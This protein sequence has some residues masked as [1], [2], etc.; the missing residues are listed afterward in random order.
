VCCAT[1]AQISSYFRPR[2]V[3]TRRD[4]V[5]ANIGGTGLRQALLQAI[6]TGRAK[7]A[8]FDHLGDLAQGA[9][10]LDAACT[11]AGSCSIVVLH[12]ARV[13]NSTVCSR[14]SHAAVALLHHDRKDKPSV[15]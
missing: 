1:Q 8:V 5:L 9:W 4:V 14:S 13:D 10:V 15:D 12:K 7:G 11:I 6:T 3:D 2:V